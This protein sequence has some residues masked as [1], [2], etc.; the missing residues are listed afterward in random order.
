MRDLFKADAYPASK[1]AFHCLYFS[2]KR[3]TTISAFSIEF[4]VRIAF[5]LAPLLSCQNFFSSSPSIFT[6]TSSDNSWLVVG[7]EN[8]ISKFLDL[9]LSI[10][11]SRQLV[12]ISPDK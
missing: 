10:I 11:S 2:P 9:H 3:T 5:I 8:S 4:L 7:L 12:W 6:P 1:A